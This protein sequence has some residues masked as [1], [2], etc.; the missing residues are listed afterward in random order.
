MIEVGLVKHVSFNT[1][2]PSKNSIELGES[3][4]WRNTRETS[5]HH[6][7]HLQPAQDMDNSFDPES[8]LIDMVY[9]NGR[10]ASE[11]GQKDP[12]PKRK[13][14]IS[15]GEFR[16][17]VAKFLGGT[18]GKEADKE[19]YL[20]FRHLYLVRSNLG[21]MCTH[22]AILPQ[23]TPSGAPFWNWRCSIIGQAQWGSSYIDQSRKR[24]VAQT[25]R[26]I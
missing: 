9:E 25:L 13:K 21:Q 2:S 19:R 6:H 18:R 23:L 4:V 1:A 12:A 5:G 26:W 17:E 8:A 11:S 22:R 20:P 24:V 15:R 3:W 10:L 14:R 16:D 7:L